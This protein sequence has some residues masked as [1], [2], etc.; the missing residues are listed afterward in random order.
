MDMG[1]DW[2]EVFRRALKYLFEGLAVGLAS[3]FLIKGAKLESV[4]M[5]AITAA[6]VYAILDLYSPS[7]GTS[8]RLGT[9]LQIG[10]SITG[11][12]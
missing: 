10:S 4:V 7:L 12:F 3:S 5:I 2:T 9:G 6:A 1:I 8:A 11:G